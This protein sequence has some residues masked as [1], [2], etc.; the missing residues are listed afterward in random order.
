MGKEQCLL[1]AVTYQRLSN[2]IFHR[3]KI[4]M[5]TQTKIKLTVTEYE[6]ILILNDFGCNVISKD[7]AGISGKDKSV[8]S[9]TINS[10]KKKGLINKIVCSED[11]RK[12]FLEITNEGQEVVMQCLAIELK[13]VEEANQQIKEFDK[14]YFDLFSGVDRKQ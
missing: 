13:L 9:R 6:L 4:A 7:I 1:W 8:I 14:E 2:E 10:L 3:L 11:K 5:Q 12:Y